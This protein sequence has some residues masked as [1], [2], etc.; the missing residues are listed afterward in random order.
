MLICD[1][2]HRIR[3]SS[4][5]QYTP[6]ARRSDER[7]IDELI[8]AAKVT[9]FLIDDK[10][11]VRPAEVG[12]S[13]LIRETAIR[14]D[15]RFVQEDLQAQFRCAGSD[16]YID[17]VDGLLKLRDSEV[18]TYDPTQ[19][20]E[21]KLF[22]A[23]EHLE[24]AIRSQVVS[25]NSARM[26]AG[27]CWKWSNPKAGALVDDVTV[28]SYRRPWNARPDATGVPKNVPKSNFWATDPHGIEQV[29]CVYTAQGFEF[30]YVGVIWGPDLVYR[31]AEG[32]W[33]G[34]KLRHTIVP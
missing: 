12:S 20:F 15:A 5:N 24:A 31:G 33:K 34:V 22:N 26:T 4:N 9:V 11:V 21:F 2:A 1:E 28:G 30:D 27:F 19:R 3:K 16:E 13:Q 8:R 14:F 10:Q 18:S 32:G 7:Q 6:A 25:G 29:G 23:P 17:W